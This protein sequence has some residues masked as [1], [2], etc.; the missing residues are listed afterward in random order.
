MSISLPDLMPIPFSSGPGSIKNA[1]PSDPQ[2]GGLASLS[3]GFPDITMQPTSSGGVP[4]YGQD[5]NGILYWITSFQTWVNAGGQFFYNSTFSSTIGGYPEGAV[6][7]S[8]DG[9]SAWVSLVP[10]NTE[11]PN[12]TDYTSFSQWAP[13]AGA[14]ATNG[15]YAHDSGSANAK[16][17]ATYP[18]S[19]QEQHGKRVSFKNLLTNTSTCTLNIGFGVKALLTDNGSPLQAG[20]LIANSVYECV[21]DAGSDAFYLVNAVSTQLATSLYAVDSGSVNAYAVTLTLPVSGSLAGLNF[22]FKASHTNT[23]AST[24]AVNGGTAHS[25]LRNDRAALQNGD[26]LIN[27]IYQVTYD[28]AA[29]AYIIVGP[30][31]SQYTTTGDSFP[32]EIRGYAGTSDPSGWFICDG[33]SLSTSTYSALYSVIGYAYGG[34]GG[35]F[36][37]PDFRDRV[38]V[39]KGSTFALG[40]TGGE[41]TH[42]LT[43]AEMP[44]HTHTYDRPSISGGTQG[45]GSNASLPV[46]SAGAVGSAGTNGAHNNVQPYGVANWVIKY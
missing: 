17:I 7:M 40:D 15:N 24:M 14:I 41:L 21:Y 16:V 20:D 13:W 10:D 35:S 3:D 22:L 5:F 29:T 38:V 27:A 45:A 4:P 34:S 37:I 2:S 9:L 44:A 8:D 32:G 43:V 30:L 33:R 18:P 12:T 1:I 11:N 6:L 31:P 39:G 23:T 42:T 26:I 28:S 36:N 19:L 25:L 46:V